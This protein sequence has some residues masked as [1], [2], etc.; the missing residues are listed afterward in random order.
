MKQTWKVLYAEQLH[1]LEVIRLPT[2][3]LHVHGM[4]SYTLNVIVLDIQV[5]FPTI[6]QYSRKKYFLSE[7]VD[8]RNNTSS[9]IPADFAFLYMKSFWQNFTIT[10]WQQDNKHWLSFL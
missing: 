2:Q 10:Y 1:H 7:I 4:K 3:N 6:A 9:T 8:C 5:N